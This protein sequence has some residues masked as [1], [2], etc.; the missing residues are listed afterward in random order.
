MNKNNLLEFTREIISIR[1]L[2]GEEGPV[3]DRIMQEMRQLGYDDAWIDQA[4]NALGLIQGDRPG[5]CILLD[6]HVDTVT[7][8]PED[9]HTDPWAADYTRRCIFGRGSAD[10]KGNLAA[11]VYGA[12]EVNRE[13]ING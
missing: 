1:S 6:A 5:K 7:A 4:G 9:W 12:A 3:V 10:T 2:T 11:M 8:N 13:E